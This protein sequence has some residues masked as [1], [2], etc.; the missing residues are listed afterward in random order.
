MHPVKV[1]DPPNSN[2]VLRQGNVSQE[3][4]QDMSYLGTNGGEDTGND[5]T[6]PVEAS[7]HEKEE[8][9]QVGKP[10]PFSHHIWDPEVR[11]MLIAYL[12]PVFMMTLIVMVMVWLFCS[13][14]WG[15]MYGYNENSP[16]IVG[17]IVNRDN[18]LIGQSIA[19]AFLDLNGNDN[20]LPR[21]TWELHDTSEFP[22]HTSLVNAVQP[23]EKFY[24]ALEIVEGATD[25]L[26]RARGA[27]DSSYDP[28]VVNII[29][30]TA[31]NPTTV[32]R[33][34][35]GPAQ[36]TF[37]KAQVKLN[38]QLTSQFLSENVNNPEAIETAN[39]APLTLVNPVASNTMDLRPWKSN[40][41]MAPT[42]VGMIY[43]VILSFQIVMAE[44]MGRFAIQPYLH[45]KAFA[46]LRIATP[47]VASFFVSVMISL[48]NIP[49]DLPFDAMF[50]Y[51][52]GFMVYWMCTLCGIVVFMLCLE[53]VITVTTPKFIGV[54][55]VLFIIS[56][57]SVSNS[58]LK[59]QPSF[60]LYGY[61]MP[62][63]NL[64][65]IYLAIMFN[66]GERL[67]IL[68]YIGIIWAWIFA[69]AASFALIIWIEYLKRFKAHKKSLE[70]NKSP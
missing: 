35:T 63:Y 24:I 47:M 32:P 27:G 23:K 28:R 8:K 26:I 56:N 13:I 40:V 31:M 6:N 12:K 4:V 57:V 9:P 58:E 1:V 18:G 3:E 70:Q 64:R 67:K 65:R 7:L 51:G 10:Q 33:Y 39:R 52:A 5:Q 49:F 45:F 48:L 46:I 61:A 68:K 2:M 20:E 25:K 41:G 21:S 50:T 34:I 59:L 44:Y 36:K 15:S 53:S 29:F 43:L 60:Y 14:Y 62:F 42:F 30:A 66:V 16:R 37:G 38:A 17:A 19:Q 55:L 69:V 11:P 54:F 22:D